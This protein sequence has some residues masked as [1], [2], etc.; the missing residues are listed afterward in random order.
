M[1]AHKMEMVFAWARE[2]GIRGYD[3]LDPASIA[4]RRQEAI[5]QYNKRENEKIVKKQQYSR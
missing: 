1:K 4:K 2:N 5:S 3:H